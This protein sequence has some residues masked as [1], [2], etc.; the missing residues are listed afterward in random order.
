VHTVKVIH[1][2]VSKNHKGRESKSIERITYCCFSNCLGDT[3]VY[4]PKYNINSPT[5]NFY[6]IGS[7][8][9]QSGDPI[10]VL[11]NVAVQ[12]VVGSPGAVQQLNQ[13]TE[14]VSLETGGDP[15]Q[16]EGMLQNLALTNSIEGGNTKQ[17][18]DNIE[19]EVTQ[20]NDPVSKS[21]NSLAA[22]E[23]QGNSEA[24]N[25]AV[26]KVAEGVVGGTDVEQQQ[27]LKEQ[28]H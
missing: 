28:Q 26:E 4:A 12:A 11:G 1:D 20:P 24:V 15:A 10:N 25:T 17:L 21:L 22:Q 18:I 27:Q 2:H 13:I 16:V 5:Y 3:F 19:M 9:V 7:L 6:S 23:E 14:D 8:I